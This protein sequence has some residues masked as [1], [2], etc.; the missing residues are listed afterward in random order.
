MT[1]FYY[2]QEIDKILWDLLGN[3]YFTETDLDDVIK[4]VTD[5]IY[6]YDQTIKK[7]NLKSVIKFVIENKYSKHYIYDTQVEYNQV[8]IGSEEKIEDDDDDNDKVRLSS[9]KDLISHHYDYKYPNYRRSTYKLRKKRVEEINK[10]PQNEQKSDAWKL[11]RTKCLTAT[12]VAVALD[13]DPYNYPIELLMDKCGKGIPFIENK[14]VH[15]GKKYEEIGNMYYSFRNNI[16]VKEYGLIQH[17]EHEFIGASPDGIC[18]ARAKDSDSLSKLVGRLL[19]IKFPKT[20]KIL[21]EGEFDGDIC[22]HQYFVQVQTQLFVTE[23]DECDFLQCEVEE[24]DSWEDFIQDSHPTI[25]GLSKETCLEKGCLIQL[26]PKDMIGSDADMCLYN[27]KY[28]YPPKLHMTKEEIEKWIA[29]ELLNFHL[30]DHSDKYMIDRIIYW[31]FTK[32]SCELIQSDSE[33]IKSKIPM[34]KQ[35]WDYVLFYRNNGEKLDELV[36]FMKTSNKKD[37]AEI[38]SKVHRDYKSVN[39]ETEYQALYQEKSYWRKKYIQKQIEYFK[40]RC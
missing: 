34:L 8:E 12:A 26:L 24:Y 28:I 39:V 31:K 6:Q 5:T 2:N 14:N 38:F 29:Q 13:E 10:I 21:T 37:S 20:R 11:Q 32:I 4:F 22:P 7:S 16:I 1:L 17:S 25:P 9:Y 18:S 27:G 40:S 33:W 36:E 3:D 30:N 19:E 15:H 23:L 35:F